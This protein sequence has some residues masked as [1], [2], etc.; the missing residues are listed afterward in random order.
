[1]QGEINQSQQYV[2]VYAQQGHSA[3]SHEY[4]TQ[5]GNSL[6]ERVESLI[7]A[8]PISLHSK[9]F[10]I[11]RDAQHDAENCKISETHHISFSRDIS[12]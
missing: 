6:K 11:K 5:D 2:Y 7:L 8:S 3:D 1:M 9:N 10:L 12:R 4:K